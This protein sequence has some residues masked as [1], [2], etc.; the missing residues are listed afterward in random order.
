M[1]RAVPILLLAVASCAPE[2]SL[3]TGAA[4]EPC[5]VAKLAFTQ[6]D[7]C[8]N[9]DGYVEF[10]VAR[11]DAALLAEVRRLAPSAR[12]VE[13]RGRAGCEPTREWLV[14]LPTPKEDPSE[15]TSDGALTPAA[16]SRVCRIASSPG[17][18]RIVPTRFE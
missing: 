17:I 1:R 13:G 12:T 4:S 9:A 15:C 2:P 6:A 10:C 8:R 16:W 3:G 5:P 14:L 7:G 18:R 11:A